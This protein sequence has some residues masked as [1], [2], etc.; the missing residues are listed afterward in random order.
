MK[1]NMTLKDYDMLCDRLNDNEYKCGNWWPS[2]EEIKKYLEPKKEEYAEFMLWIVET[3]DAPVTDEEKASRNYLNR[4]L[5]N[6]IKIK[7]TD[8]Y[9][10]AR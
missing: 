2:V 7:Y 1:L 5:T 3:A 6:T 10:E 9:D 4:L 8:D